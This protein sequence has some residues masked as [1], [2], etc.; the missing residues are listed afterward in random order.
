MIYVKSVSLLYMVYVNKSDQGPDS[1]R[2]D[3]DSK[4]KISPLCQIIYN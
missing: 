2:V 1:P 4:D 3:L